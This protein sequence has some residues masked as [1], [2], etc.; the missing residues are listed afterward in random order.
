M[1]DVRQDILSPELLK[2]YATIPISFH[3]HSHFVVHD[4]AG[5]WRLTE[6][7]GTSFFK[8]Y[9]TLDHPMQWIAQFD[10]SGWMTFSA[11]QNSQ[12]VGGAIVAIRTPG[13]NM[14]D[15]R[16]DLAV[17]WDMRVHPDYRK[18]NVGAALFREILSW[19]KANGCRELKVETQQI[20][21]AACKF[22]Q[23]MG[24]ELR[25]VREDQ[26]PGLS[27]EIQLLWYREL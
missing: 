17:L 18:Q 24:C 25:E 23:K 27:D 20:N 26:Y 7:T 9:D 1:I 14:L 19:S 6:T 22:Y 16:D 5:H 4:E 21:V 10:T 12:R 11:F 13:V 3:S 2:D 8:D 15:G